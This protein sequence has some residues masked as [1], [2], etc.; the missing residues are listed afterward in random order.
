[1]TSSQFPQDLVVL[2]ADK[3][4]EHALKGILSRPKALNIRKSI[5]VTYYI[6]PENDPGCFKEGHLLLKPFIGRFRHALLLFDYEGSGQERKSNSKDLEAEIEKRLSET[7]WSDR[8]AVVVID[9]ELEIW[10]WS[11]S[12]HIDYAL[13]WKDKRPCLRE[14]MKKNGYL[15]EGK[16]KPDTPK[17]TLEDALRIAKKPRSSSI[18]KEIARKVSLERCVD[19]SFVRLKAILQKW[20]PVE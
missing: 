20:F 14:W 2:V 9:P 16:D 6:H 7:G 12:V 8:A 4:M 19:P 11:N 5:S 15:T 3:N 17:K 10:V 18:Y 1:M 13:G